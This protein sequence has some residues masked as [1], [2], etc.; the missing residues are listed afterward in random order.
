MPVVLPTTVA[1]LVWA[2]LY[3]VK[4]GYINVLLQ[5]VGVAKPPNW[6]GSPKWA[7][8]SMVLPTVWSRLWLLDAA[9]PHRHL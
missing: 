4:F 9:L 8:F 7:L 2:K 5:G 6:L 3:D 1:M